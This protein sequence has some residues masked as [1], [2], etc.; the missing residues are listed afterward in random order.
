MSSASPLFV[1]FKS[2]TQRVMCDPGRAFPLLYQSLSARRT[3]LNTFM[4][5]RPC[6]LQ[7]S[8]RDVNIPAN[9]LSGASG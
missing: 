4:A 2:D 7:K 1:K 9:S 6:F 8:L 5:L 3:Q